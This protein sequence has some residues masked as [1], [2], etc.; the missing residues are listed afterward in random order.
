MEDP[1]DNNLYSARLCIKTKR[2]ALIMD[3]CELFWRGKTAMVRVKEITG[4]LPD[5]VNPEKGDGRMHENEDDDVSIDTKN[6]DVMQDDMHDLTDVASVVNTKLKSNEQDDK[7]D[8]RDR[9]QNSDPFE[10]LPVI[11]KVMGADQTNTETPPY[12]PGFTPS[13]SEQSFE[14]H[15]DFGKINEAAQNIEYSPLE[16]HAE[17]NVNSDS[18]GVRQ[19]SKDQCGV[20]QVDFGRL[21]ASSSRTE[22]DSF[23][24]KGDGSDKAENEK[25]IQSYSMVD[26]LSKMIDMG[27]AM[28]LNMSGC[29]E[30]MNELLNNFVDLRHSESFGVSKGSK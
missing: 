23:M 16:L 4:W 5:F 13:V 25:V 21:D 19:R 29:E 15:E 12:P 1:K 26:H 17:S 27:V 18:G 28:G 6:E 3:T 22:T 7:D 20:K 30:N 8:D 9:V 10:L 11:E 14:C 2:Q 24:K